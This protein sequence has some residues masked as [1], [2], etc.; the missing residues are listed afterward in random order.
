VPGRAA[1]AGFTVRAFDLA[2]DQWTPFENVPSRGMEGPTIQRATI[3]HGGRVEYRYGDISDNALVRELIEGCDAV[4]HCT[5]YFPG[6]DNPGDDLPWTINVKGLWN[7]LDCCRGSETIQRVVHI[8]SCSTV[9]PGSVASPERGSV[10]FDASV[11]RPDTSLYSATKRLQEELCRQFHDSDG[12][13]IVV[14]RPDGIMDLRHSLTRVGGQGSARGTAPIESRPGVG[15]VCRFD[16]A[17]ACRGAIDLGADHPFEVL[18]VATLDTSLPA[19]ER[20]SAFCNVQRTASLL[21]VSFEHDLSS[22]DAQPK[23]SL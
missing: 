23:A 3:G 15:S 21:G 16:I 7:I 5:A 1:A 4:V 22:Y 13:P 17:A 18:H 11:R 20:A 8:G 10:F 14:L 2:V 9:W 6:G 19:A 12:L